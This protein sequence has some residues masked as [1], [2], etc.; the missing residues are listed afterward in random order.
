MPVVLH[1]ECFR[2]VNKH[3]LSVTSVLFKSQFIVKCF[4]Q[5]FPS[6]SLFRSLLA[7]VLGNPVQ[8]FVVLGHHVSV[9]VVDL[10]T[11][12]VKDLRVDIPISEDQYSDA[13]KDNNVSF[14][15]S[16]LRRYQVLTL[17][18][19]E[20]LCLFLTALLKINYYI[21]PLS[22]TYMFSNF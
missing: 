3:L 14:G 11:M 18:Y 19:C 7:V 9:I 1:I 16:V 22:N 20:A 2:Y 10:Q 17:H 8:V 5:S 13:L 6:L 21:L 12:K 4:S 15:V